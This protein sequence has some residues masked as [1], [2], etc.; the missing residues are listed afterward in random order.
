[1]MES[2][3]GKSM[4]E[5]H[6]KPTQLL[7][8]RL[9][10]EQRSAIL[11]KSCTEFGLA[12][13]ILIFGSCDARHEI[14]HRLKYDGSSASRSVFISILLDA[15]RGGA[16]MSRQTTPFQIPTDILNPR[17]PLGN[18]NDPCADDY[19]Y[20]YIDVKR[21]CKYVINAVSEEMFHFRHNA[22]RP[23]FEM[24]EHVMIQ[25]PSAGGASLADPDNAMTDQS[26]TKSQT[27]LAYII[28]TDMEGGTME[29]VKLTIDGESPFSW[30]S[31]RKKK[32][33]PVLRLGQRSRMKQRNSELDPI[34]PDTLFPVC[35]VPQAPEGPM[36]IVPSICGR[37]H[38]ALH[39]CWDLDSYVRDKCT[40]TN[41][42]SDTILPQL[43]YQLDIKGCA[44]ANSQWKLAKRVVH[45][46]EQIA[47]SIRSGKVDSIVPSMVVVPGLCGDMEYQFRVR[48][49]FASGWTAFGPI[50][51]AY[52]TE[53][54]GQKLSIA[55]VMVY[56]HDPQLQILSIVGMM[57]KNEGD[58][59]V[60]QMGCSALSQLC[61]GEEAAEIIVE[62]KGLNLVGKAMAKYKFDK[63]IAQSGAY[64]LGRIALHSHLHS[65]VGEL[66]DEK[67]EP[68][69]DALLVDI[70][71]RFPAC[72]WQ[73]VH[74]A[75]QWAR[76]RL[77]NP[78]K[79]RSKPIQKKQLKKVRRGDKG[80]YDN[81][82]AREP[83]GMNAAA[84]Y[85]Q[86][87]YRG[88]KA[89]QKMQTV[90]LDLTDKVRH[91]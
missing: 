18:E 88:K 8:L 62:E 15:L 68:N 30:V 34:S 91:K 80:A 84:S 83:M 43:G 59:F 23:P 32:A 85:I 13:E 5:K 38:W 47:R 39:L 79:P 22:V 31:K 58:N 72:H 17:L 56:Q 4:A 46:Y 86:G 40:W 41:N 48:F 36:H 82:T 10:N 66:T 21:M 11:T 29:N 53:A 89:Y 75:A 87:L 27:P 1:M 45:P 64:V 73:A 69:A 35:F 51:D 60:Q 7:P 65:F 55:Q 70:M 74:F 33:F 37:T 61:F 76:E 14:S 16:A 2:Y 77:L 9:S 44:R 6:T 81:T 52:R 50:T 26:E 49:C 63:N 42:G 19:L 28:K 54:Q 3:D 12:R 78:P 25:S 24:Q 90:L 71:Q 57:R 20:R 67:N